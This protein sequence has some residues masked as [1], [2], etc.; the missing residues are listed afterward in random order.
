MQDEVILD[1]SVAAKVFIT[2]ADSE[3]ARA[4]AGSGTQLIAP[5]LIF[6]EVASVAVKRLRRGDISLSLAEAMVGSLASLISEAVPIAGLANRAFKLAADH[7]LS[8]YDAT[9]VALAEKRGCDLVTADLRLIA[10][11]SRS[12][13]SVVVRTA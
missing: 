4:L 6:A 12:G 3:S 9:Y 5:D 8:A 10:L 7:G 2:E 13:L 11:V 1:A